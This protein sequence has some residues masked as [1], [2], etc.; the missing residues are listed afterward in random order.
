MKQIWNVIVLS[1]LS[2]QLLGQQIQDPL[3]KNIEVIENIKCYYFPNEY[4][5]ACFT[6]SGNDYKFDRFYNNYEAIVQCEEL[7]LILV[8]TQHDSNESEFLFIQLVS[9]ISSQGLLDKS[10][11]N[12]N[13]EVLR[14]V[15]FVVFDGI[16]SSESETHF[17]PY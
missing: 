16:V 8:S 7:S 11:F 17:E 14:T 9:P 15:E 5:F 6:K 10:T 12:Y 2:I 1:L 13:S 3:Q 4:N